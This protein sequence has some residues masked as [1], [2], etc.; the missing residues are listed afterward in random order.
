MLG[1]L[2]TFSLGDRFSEE[3]IRKIAQKARARF[4]GMSGLRS[5]ASPAAGAF[6]TDEL[7]ERVTGLYGVRP[8]IQFLQIESLVDNARS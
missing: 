5:N 6:F 2:L 1:V 4:E 8:T 7:V 3:T